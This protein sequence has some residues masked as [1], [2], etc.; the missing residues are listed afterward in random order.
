MRN[1]L[2]TLTALTLILGALLAMSR[3]PPVPPA[4]FIFMNGTEP[5]TVDP[6]K[7][8]GVP[9][10]HIMIGLFQGLTAHDT[11]TLKV[12]PGMA[13]SW[14]VSP[15]GMT[16]TFHL[17]EAKWSDGKP[18][19]ADDVLYSIERVLRP[20]TASEYSYMVWELPNAEAYTSGK[21]KLYYPVPMGTDPA[22]AMLP[23]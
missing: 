3:R 13:K 16:Y 10:W 7:A 21:L 12:I 20:E 19:T 23:S 6:H 5:E 9:E 2:L 1:L 15:D 22:L 11:R 8:T 17:R 18:F 14:E 4:D